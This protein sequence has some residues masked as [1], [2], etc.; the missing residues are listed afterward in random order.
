MSDDWFFPFIFLFFMLCCAIAAIVVLSDL[1]NI[2][3]KKLESCQSEL[4]SYKIEAQNK[5]YNWKYECDTI[6]DW[7]VC[8]WV[9]LRKNETY[10]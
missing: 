4:R 6:K 8:R 1:M 5:E 10:G 7:T 9:G 3:S 2:T